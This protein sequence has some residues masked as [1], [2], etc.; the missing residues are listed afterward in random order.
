MNDCFSL[1]NILE[2]CWS[3]HFH[4]NSQSFQDQCLTVL[5]K[6]Y[7]NN[8]WTVGQSYHGPTLLYWRLSDF[9]MWIWN[10]PQIECSNLGRGHPDCNQYFTGQSGTVQ[11]YNWPT[12]Q[13]DSKTHNICIRR[14]LGKTIKLK[15][16]LSYNYI[17][18]EFTKFVFISADFALNNWQQS[19][20]TC[21]RTRHLKFVSF[22]L[23]QILPFSSHFLGYCGIQYSA[24]SA[25]T[26]DSFVLDVGIAI[27]SNNVSSNGFFNHAL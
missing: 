26:P 8:N 11:S 1:V 13:L 23:P 25:T 5:F 6:I 3:I 22:L 19:T 20:E 2:F 9:K 27:T 15:D 21:R 10:P 7:L 17:L 16:I 18:V 14:E 24:Y 4:S 12:I